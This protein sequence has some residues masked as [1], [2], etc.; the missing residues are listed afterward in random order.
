[1]KKLWDWLKSLFTGERI[2]V[3]W[4]TIFTAAKSSLAQMVCDPE[5]QQKALDLVRDLASRLHVHVDMRQMGVRDE[6]RTVGG[7][8]PNFL[9]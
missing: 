4:R 2:G 3:I 9:G 7:I 8:G 6:A 1:M 5:N